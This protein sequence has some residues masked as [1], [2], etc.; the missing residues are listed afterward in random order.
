ME[1]LAYMTRGVFNIYLFPYQSLTNML[2]LE[3]VETSGGEVWQR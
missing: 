2:W 3:A 1:F